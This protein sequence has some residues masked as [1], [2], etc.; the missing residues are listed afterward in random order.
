MKN[1]ENIYILERFDNQIRKELP[2]YGNQINDCPSFINK[3]LFI[4]DESTD[5]DINDCKKM[6]N[7]NYFKDKD[8]LIDTKK[9]KKT[10]KQFK[11]Y[12]RRR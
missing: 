10:L 3:L 7:E 9:T 8:H 12:E 1:I 6:R 4:I 11:Q 2:E 5:M